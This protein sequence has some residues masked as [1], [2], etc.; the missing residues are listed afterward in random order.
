MAAGMSTIAKSRIS[1]TD[2]FHL[3]VRF[4]QARAHAHNG[5]QGSGFFLSCYSGRCRRVTPQ[6]RGVSPMLHHPRLLCANS[7]A[8]AAALHCDSRTVRVEQ[9]Q[10]TETAGMEQSADSTRGDLREPVPGLLDTLFEPKVASDQGGV[11]LQNPG[12]LIL[13]GSLPASPSWAHSRFAS[14]CG[15]NRQVA[16]FTYWSAYASCMFYEGCNQCSSG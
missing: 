6:E 10:V 8:A 7:W 3:Q 9:N 16:L 4:P 5:A 2:C 11:L 14:G 12:H 13:L 15:P 1:L